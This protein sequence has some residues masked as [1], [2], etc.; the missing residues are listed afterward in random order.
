MNCQPYAT[1][2]MIAAPGR[3]PKTANVFWVIPFETNQMMQRMST[4]AEARQAAGG[5]KMRMLAPWDM[6]HGSIVGPCRRC[7]SLY[8]LPYSSVVEQVEPANLP[9]FTQMHPQLACAIPSQFCVILMQSFP[10]RSAKCIA[11]KSPVHPCAKSLWR[12]LFFADAD[13]TDRIMD[14]SC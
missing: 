3:T 2:G 11:L 14:F 6:G 5:F 9:K 10:S 12:D 8:I 7:T 4:S 13:A 1:A